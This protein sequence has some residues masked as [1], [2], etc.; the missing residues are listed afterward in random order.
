MT[1]A[2]AETTP[3]QGGPEQNPDALNQVQPN[4][5]VDVP[6]VQV[7][8]AKLGRGNMRRI[9]KARDE[10]DKA[11]ADFV[12]AMD[13]LVFQADED[14]NRIGRWPL[15]DAVSEARELVLAE[16]SELMAQ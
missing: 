2:K 5:G 15:L 7:K 14:G 9:T 1:K 16:I 10:L 12:K 13:P 8:R 3:D 6:G 11:M 4:E